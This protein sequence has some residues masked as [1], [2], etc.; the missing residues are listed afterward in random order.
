MNSFNCFQWNFYY[1]Q[2]IPDETCNSSVHDHVESL[3]EFETVTAKFHF[4]DLAGSE[5]LKRTGATG[6]RQKESICINSGLVSN[7]ELQLHFNITVN[8]VVNIF[9]DL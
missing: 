5:R 8:F 6:D 1:W 2:T 7:L 4:V 3:N 9:H